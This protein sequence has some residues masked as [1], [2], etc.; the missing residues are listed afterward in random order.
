MKI[1]INNKQFPKKYSNIS[2]FER[3]EKKILYI[4]NLKRYVPLKLYNVKRKSKY[5]DEIKKLNSNINDILCSFYVYQTSDANNAKNSNTNEISNQTVT[6]LFNKTFNN[7]NNKSLPFYLTETEPSTFN[8][9]KNLNHKKSSWHKNLKLKKNLSEDNN[10]NSPHKLSFQNNYKTFRKLS[11]FFV[12]KENENKKK[13]KINKTFDLIDMKL[14]Q[15]KIANHDNIYN[16]THYIDKNRKLMQLKYNS[17]I[18]KEAIQR[19]DENNDNSKQLIDNKIASLNNL[20]KLYN[21]VFSGKLIEYIRFINNIKDNEEIFDLTLINQIYSLKS[22]ISILTN[23]IKKIQKEKNNIIQWILLQIMVKEKKSDLPFYY[24]QLLEMSLPKMK[25]QRR[26]A[27]ADVTKIKRFKT[28][29]VKSVIINTENIMKS[30]T[31]DSETILE[32][33]NQK[34]FNK[35]M[36]YRQNLIFNSPDDFFEE[37]DCIENKNIKL[38]ERLDFLY[39]DIRQL[40]KQ[41]NDLLNSKD[42]LNSSFIIQINKYENELKQNKQIYLERKKYLLECKDIHIDKVKNN[43]R[44]TIDFNLKLNDSELLLTKKK[45]KLLTYVEKLFSTCKE[46]KLGKGFFNSN[47]KYNI[48]INRENKNQRDIILNMLEYI[49]VK[50]TKLL[51]EFSLYKNPI[52]PY[53]DF[54]R[55]LRVNYKRKRNIEKANL[56]RIENE[57]KN[58]QLL[59]EIE[60]KNGQYLFLENNKKDLKNHLGKVNSQTSSKTKKKIKLYIPKIEDFLYD[61]LLKKSLY[62]EKNEE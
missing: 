46:I 9:K 50:I 51:L 30:F 40:K 43:K 14:N 23:K 22:E 49:E 33:I 3:R 27:K 44:K 6:S 26:V 11:D 2:V 1:N 31:I 10:I 38:F 57:K 37:I 45:S 47:T 21:Q 35:I 53:Y 19:N 25:N 56:A 29:K 16:V 39:Y 24:T 59:Q 36:Y 61:N 15:I 4:K 48:I 5:E 42:F 32:D 34:E 62:S 54:I 41:Y 52:N 8:I 7:F 13:R 60:A 17:L 55:K 12:N 58:I 20:K 28:K 18:T